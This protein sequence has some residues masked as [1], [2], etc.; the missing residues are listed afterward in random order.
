MAYSYNDLLAAAFDANIYP[1]ISQQVDLKGA[2]NFSARDVMKNV[3]LKSGKRM[4]ALPSAL[5]EDEYDY[6]APSDLKDNSICDIVPQDGR[7]PSDRWKMYT[8]SDYDRYKRSHRGIMTVDILA[9]VPRIR[10]TIK[11]QDLLQLVIAQLDSLTGDGGTWSSFGQ[12]QNVRVDNVDFIKGSGSIKFDYLTGGTTVGIQNTT[13]TPFD[14]STYISNAQS[15]FLRAR[16][17]QITNLQSVT[18]RLGT[19]ASNYIQIVA[20]VTV[21]NT[22]MQQG[23]NIIRLDFSSLTTVGSPSTTAAKYA[24]LFFTLSSSGTSSSNNWGFDFLVAQNGKYNNFAYYTKCAWQDISGNYIENTTVT[25]DTLVADSMDDFNLFVKALRVEVDRRLKDYIA[26]EID[27][28]DL[29]SDY[30]KYQF[31]HPS[32][33]LLLEQPYY[34]VETMDYVDRNHH[35]GWGGLTD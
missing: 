25:T 12:A 27:Q 4:T 9:N 1:S 14:I 29:S 13:L 11:C 16:V 34:E 31:D 17:S 7:R 23:W 28:A 19:D 15:M 24:A 32:E 35:H 20:T 30:K 5:F 8:P 22:A 26:Y 6:Q 33:A 18:V 3:D 10:A 2:A 21:V